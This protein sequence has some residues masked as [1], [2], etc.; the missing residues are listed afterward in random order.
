MAPLFLV[1]GG[2]TVVPSSS[3]VALLGPLPCGCVCI[4]SDLVMLGL[5]LSP[6]RCRRALV[7]LVWK[8]GG[9]V[10]DGLE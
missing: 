9:L 5:S 10:L 3:G 4:L 2:V 8:R 1:V 7:A 6:A